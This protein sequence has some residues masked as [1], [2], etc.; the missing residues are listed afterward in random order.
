[1]AIDA[2][3]MVPHPPLAVSEVGRGEE[4]KIQKTIDSYLEVA[5]EIAEIKSKNI[6]YL[7]QCI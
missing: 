6:F 3:F 2:F 7:F 1:M 5:K 4:K